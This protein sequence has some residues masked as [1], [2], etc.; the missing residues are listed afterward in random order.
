ML[1]GAHKGAVTP[2]KKSAKGVP[3]K[4]KRELEADALAAA[5]QR[6]QRKREGGGGLAVAALD[7]NRS[8][9]DALEAVRQARL[10]A[11]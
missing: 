1:Q 10:A 11:L 7:R 6:R 4:S 5:L 3:R 8:G 9:P 2:Q